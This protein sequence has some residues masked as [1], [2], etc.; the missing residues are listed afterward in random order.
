MMRMARVNGGRGG[1]GWGTEGRFQRQV[2][3]GTVERRIRQD[4]VAD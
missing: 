3:L 2:G 4:L 1:G